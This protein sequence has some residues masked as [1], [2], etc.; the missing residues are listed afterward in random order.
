MPRQ[1]QAVLVA[2][3]MARAE[4]AC[5]AARGARAA[6]AVA[7]TL[8]LCAP[9]ALGAI[10]RYHG[11]RFLAVGDAFIFR[12]GREG[13]VARSNEADLA[14]EEAAA[15]AA[16]ARVGRNVGTGNTF[17][18]FSKVHFHRT[19]QVAN[20]Y[21]AGRVTNGKQNYVGMVQAVVFEVGDRDRIGHVMPDGRTR[22]FC[23]TP[24]LQAQTGCEAD[25]LIV[26]ER[27][28]EPGWPWVTEIFYEDNATVAYAVDD[29]VVID[30]TGMYYLWFVV[31]D[32]NLAGVSIDGQTTWKNPT[33]YLPGMM[34]PNLDLFM[35][36][37][38]AYGVLAAGWLLAYAVHW[39]HIMM[40][41][42]CISA[43]IFLSLVEMSA[44]YFDFEKFNMT[45]LRP[46]GVTVF[47][48]LAGAAR[49][50]VSRLLVLVVSMGYGVVKP[51]LGGITQQVLSLTAAY[52]VATAALDIMTNVGTVDD[53]DSGLRVILV[54]PVAV[55]DAVFIL[56]IFTSLSRTL[57]Q[58]QAR[59][60]S[61]K[62]DMYRKFTNAL[63][64]M[65]LFSIA[66]IVYEMMFK[67]SD[68]YNE[69]WQED[70]IT[71]AYWHV[72]SFALLLIICVLWMP[73]EHSVKYAY[74]EDD[75]A[76]VWDEV[77]VITENFGDDTGKA[78]AADVFALEEEDGNAKLE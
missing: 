48:V 74:H 19:Q 13:L 51:T 14:D 62:L 40:L 9:T 71:T 35:W 26:K 64:L 65:V 58:L 15:T 53:L 73:R 7:V 76:E 8:L 23:C 5:G 52:A 49:K 10:H 66:F 59:R 36:M 41:Q 24:T 25:R 46:E 11:E 31:C 77:D 33:G 63:A 39:R 2:G 34:A 18:R 56:W 54:L 20:E 30:S 6:L 17:I 4:R 29:A 32:P 42:H 72:L 61:A 28:D 69:R 47:A 55:L 22:R 60:Q 27:E 3:A 16:T 1:W 38:I 57:A 68:K 12:G 21:A 50:S 43:V 70:W 78:I 44:W 45:G 37:S 75:V 67:I